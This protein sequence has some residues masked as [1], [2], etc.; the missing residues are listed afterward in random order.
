M[1]G[2]SGEIFCRREPWQVF[3]VP[4]DEAAWPKQGGIMAGGI[5][6]GVISAAVVARLW[7]TKLRGLKERHDD[8]RLKG[9]ISAV[10]LS[11]ATL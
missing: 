8:E 5:V 2:G 6:S 3:F 4:G 9:I 7:T 1:V 10:L 11:Q